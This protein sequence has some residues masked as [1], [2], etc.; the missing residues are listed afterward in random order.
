MKL[1]DQSIRNYHT[2]TVMVVLAAAVG[3]FCFQILPR[4]LTP[5]VDK[6]IIEVRTEY[7][8]LSPN[9]VERNITR[10]LEE[11]L[12]SVEGLKKMT[13]RSQQGLSTIT[14][15]FDWGTDKNIATIDV[16]NKLQQVKDLPV[17]SDKPTL[18]SVSSDNSSPIMWI[19][20]DKPNPKMPDLDQNYMYK[21][22]EDIVI[23]TLLRVTGVA[24]VWHFG[25]EEREMRVEFDPYS[26]ARLHL[27]YKDVIDRLSKENQNTRAGFH[28]EAN[29][30]YTV[31]T[32]GEF[33]SAEEILNT[34]V[35]RDGERTLTVRDFATVVD[36]YQRTASLVR[37]SG[38]LSNVF[39]IIRKPGANVVE[40]C[41]LTAEA[42]TTLNK[43]LLSRGIPLRLN[44]VYKDVDYI[45]E[46]M[47]LV[48]SNLGLGAVLAVIVLLVFL[49]SIRS[50]LIV[51]I[52]IPAS[53]VAVFI[54]LKL[55]GRS[56][57][58]ISLAG[59][60]FA[61][62]MVV[63][64]SIVVLENIYRHLTMRKGVMKAA[65]D[66]ASEV[67]GAVLASTLTTLAVFVPIV[68]IEEEAGQM[69]KD[70][71]ITISASIALSLLVS[72]T[73]IPTLV[74]LLI[75]LKPGEPYRVGALHQKLLGPVIFLGE[76]IKRGYTVLIRKLLSRSLTSIVSKVGIVAGVAFLLWWST[77][78]LPEPD[79]LPYGNT[80]MVFMM[81]EPVAGVPSQRNME[82]FADYEKKIVNMEDVTRNFLVF[83]QRFNG[84]GAIIDPELAHGQRGEVK[85]AVK[86]QE[87][88][89]EIFKI[90]G[91]RFAFAVQRPIFRSADKTFQVEI[92]GPDM[93]KLKSIAQQLIGDIS[94]IPGVHSVRPQFKFGNPEL[95]FIPKRE[96][97]ARLDMGMNEIGNIVESLNAGKYLGE[98]NDRGEP[99]DFVFVQKKDRRKLSLQDYKDLPIWTDEGMMTN[100]GNL[101][102][103]EV[104][105][106][107][108][109]IDHIEKE[110]AINLQIQVKKDVAMQQVI[111]AVEKKT[112][113]P[114][115][116]TL[117]EEFGLRTGG[118][119]DELTSTQKSLQNSFIYA[120]G[121]IYLLLVALF[122]S[123]L[124]PI[125]VML[126][127][128]FA[129]SGAFLGIV[130]NNLLQRG[131]IR[132]IL[133]EW[134]VPNAEDMAAGW[135]WIT[136]DILTQLG[137]IILAG[138][139]VNNAILIIH[140]MLNNI[141]A[142]M[143]E[144]KALEVSCET[145]LRPIMMTVISSVF[146]MVPLAFGEGSGTELYRGMGTALIG[147][148]SV[149]AVFTLFLVPVLIS[150]MMDMGFH[151]TKEDLVKESLDQT[152]THGE[153]PTN[154]PAE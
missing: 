116:Q 4:Q 52:S 147:G 95:R 105:A 19:V 84:G 20:F 47:R 115:R 81:I 92:T 33:T 103:L 128:T 45:D 138:I 65:Y 13:S 117:T 22:G 90:P 5:T 16:N 113:A 54:V 48:K 49:G 51:A 151:T 50:V 14:L 148:L 139:V 11:Q 125:I 111:N 145:R 123:F 26:L 21:V 88:G 122:A 55:L 1:I 118:S 71:A 32:L 66:G 31:R 86:S 85:M 129:I 154:I 57:N 107:P 78:I 61:V 110:R 99:I 137:I 25:G 41:N 100:L 102:D 108:A 130:G 23:P 58:I 150:L 37:I 70:I 64:N 153:S 97:A 29:R 152:P 73:V 91:Y 6:P 9:E 106:G 120:V 144:R 143:D 114:V 146:G 83:S 39:G 24:D 12:E 140:Q 96:Q 93:L 8:G 68:F 75:R 80:N 127:V 42:V 62:G 40:T 87:M 119:A 74:T 36:G 17:L 98:F 101:A 15:E 94:S 18:K 44:I 135:N 72:I 131:F 104:D 63:D 38:M 82:Y 121:F 53:L 2:V 89:K 79:Y 149:S 132:S 34:V 76:G 28:D 109:R 7:R 35:K 27:T 56:I 112:L 10:R 142:G 46:S 60:A 69:F 3:I 30:E 134:N 124:R 77:K 67:W 126:T 59:M 136:F 133:E 141:R 43:E